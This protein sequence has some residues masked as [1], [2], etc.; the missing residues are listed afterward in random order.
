MFL[1]GPTNKSSGY[2]LG[3]A[4]N[5][6]VVNI[7]DDCY[8]QHESLLN[9]DNANSTTP[10]TTDSE[11]NASSEHLTDDF[12][13]TLDD[14]E[15][16]KTDLQKTIPE[17]YKSDL[18]YSSTSCSEITNDEELQASALCQ[19]MD[20]LNDLDEVLDKSLLT[21]LD[22]G[23]KLDSDDDDDVIY[24]I[25]EAKDYNICSDEEQSTSLDDDTQVVL[26]TNHSWTPTIEEEDITQHV[27]D[28]PRYVGRS[29]S[30]SYSDISTNLRENSPAQLEE[31]QIFSHD[32]RS[33]MR[34]LDPIV[35]PA[36]TQE[37]PCESLTLPVILFLEHHVNMRPTSAPI[38]LQVT[39]ANVGSAPLIVGRR[40]LVMN[41]ALSLPSPGESD[42]A[43]REWSERNTGRSTTRSLSTSSSSTE[44]FN[45]AVPPQQSSTAAEER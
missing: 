33:S 37:P 39:T 13:K 31:P 26:H 28:K 15:D 8:E 2:E 19:F 12:E 32:L 36:I 35:L 22:D 29:R 44:S 10:Y 42:S 16:L 7:S 21:C 20:I 40:A 27:S 9:E 18:S 24:K 30:K 23:G 3:Q 6:D 4:I 41:R 1:S 43:I 25:K 45:G 38:Q 14:G 11:S 5:M 34:R 17:C